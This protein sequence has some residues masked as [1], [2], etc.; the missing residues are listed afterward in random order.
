MWALEYALLF[1]VPNNKW[2]L[3]KGR[4]RCACPFL[5]RATG[6]AHFAEWTD[7][8]CRWQ[9]V[10]PSPP[11]RKKPKEWKVRVGRFRMSLFSRPIELRIPLDSEVFATVYGLGWRRDLWVGQPPG[12]ETGWESAQRHFDV[13]LRLW[14]LFGDLCA[15]YGGHQSGRVDIAVSD[16]V[17]IAPDQYYFRGSKEECMIA[18]DY[19]QGVPELIAEVL[20]PA[21]R[22]ID[23]GPRKELY[24]RIG[25]RHLW[26][27]D[28]ELETVVIYELEGS[29]Y[30]Q[31]ATFHAGDEFRPRLFP[32][33]RVAVDDLF[34][35][36]WKRKPQWRGIDEPQPVSAWLA[37][38]ETRL[39][40]EY[41]LLLGHPDRRYEIWHNRAP[42]VLAFG[43]A[44]E[45]QVRF[46]HFLEDM[47]R[48]EQ[49][50]LCQPSAIEPG[51]EVAEVGRFHLTRR[52]RLVHL[53]VAVD[54]RKYREMLEVWTHRKAWD[55]GEK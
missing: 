38:R 54:A 47:C 13:Q 55:W 49:Q 7:T 14:R 41:L 5:D 29:H 48:W 26:L 42:C 6:E 36:Q 45:G 30:Q 40:L 50:P 4:F 15:K 10:A 23:Q 39:G 18:G 21:S 44:E 43:S 3:L 11:V 32:E 46:G 37:P 51:V 27:L 22:A 8:L 2:E 52:G 16:S 25:V 53:E 33:V 34:D 31:V 12:R 28:P 19:F 35:T 24:R 1:G 17:A 9:Q 20:S